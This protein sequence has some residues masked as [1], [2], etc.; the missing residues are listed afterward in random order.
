MVLLRKGEGRLLFT[1]KAFLDILPALS[2]VGISLSLSPKELHFVRQR[3][4]GASMD[5]TKS[6]TSDMRSGFRGGG[7][8]SLLRWQDGDV[9]RQCICT[10]ATLPSS[11]LPR[12]DWADMMTLA[13]P[14]AEE[15]VELM[16][17]NQCLC[18]SIRSDGF[19]LRKI[20]FNYTMS[21]KPY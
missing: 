8:T 20:C 19:R 15:Y 21:A 17:T 18:R 11:L 14:Q 5:Q 7:K 4:A 9:K 16:T 12:P 1:T 10:T 2:F 13:V 6:E 3:I